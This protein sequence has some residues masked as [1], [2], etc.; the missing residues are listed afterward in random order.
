[1][2]QKSY[3][4]PGERRLSLGA[5]IRTVDSS[6][7]RQAAIGRGCVKTQKR[8]LEFVSRLR[9]FSVGV[10]CLLAGRYRRLSRAIASRVVF[11]GN[12]WG[13]TVVVFSHSLGQKQTLDTRVPVSRRYSGMMRPCIGLHLISGKQMSPFTRTNCLETSQSVNT[14]IPSCV[15][16]SRRS[17]ID[18][19]ESPCGSFS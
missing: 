18:P 14:I 6:A 11:E 17:K 12:T 16:I 4:L 8:P 2:L 7:G 19:Y 15:R 10:S 9:E 1:M 3:E 13:E 5:V